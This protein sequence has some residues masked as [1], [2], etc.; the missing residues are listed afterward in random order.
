M[1]D[2]ENETGGDSA[3][4]QA[5]DATIKQLVPGTPAP[6]LEMVLGEP[7]RKVVSDEPGE[8][9]WEY[10]DPHRPRVTHRFF[11]T[12][13][14]LSSYQKSILSSGEGTDHSGFYAAARQLGPGTP[15]QALKVM[16]GE[17]AHKTPSDAI[18][19]VVW[20]YPDPGRPR[21]VHRFFV[22]DEVVIRSEEDEVTSERW[23]ELHPGAPE[24]DTGP[25]PEDLA[26]I[27][28]ETK[29][30][31]N[32]ATIIPELVAESDRTPEYMLTQFI[33]S[34]NR[35]EVVSCEHRQALE[36]IGMDIGDETES[37]A[38]RRATRERI[39]EVFCTPKSKKDISIYSWPPHYDPEHDRIDEVKQETRS[40][41]TIITRPP[42]ALERGTMD[43]FRYTLLRKGGQWLIDKKESLSVDGTWSKWSL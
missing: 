26:R 12:R 11:V 35:W 37:E 9:V 5:Y 20:E 14:A 30:L 28:T 25:S 36:A 31:F 10:Q 32:P 43:V 6:L 16:L 15:E 18:G 7:T 4:T 13:G 1:N 27:F 8:S 2:S 3:V 17:P 24:S 21:I 41:V 29:A 42:K 39:R 22:S 40:R 23:H 34:M 38:Y 19:E 33:I